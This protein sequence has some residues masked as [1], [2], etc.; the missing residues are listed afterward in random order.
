MLFPYAL[1]RQPSDE[2]L[3]APFDTMPLVPQIV[4]SYLWANEGGS[5]L[6]LNV[7]HDP[8]DICLGIGGEGSTH[9]VGAL[10]AWPVLC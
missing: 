7:D 8:I 3:A 10:L 4:I 2:G 1:W 6:E 9:F 5:G